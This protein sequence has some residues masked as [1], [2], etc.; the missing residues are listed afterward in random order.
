MI[1]AGGPPLLYAVAQS[2]GEGARLHRLRALPLLVLLGTGLSLGNAL[3]VLRALAGSSRGFQRTPKYALRTNQDTWV[4]S[5][6]AGEAG[7]SVWGELVLALY[8]LAL[9]SVP[10]VHWGL[11]PWLLVYAG[12]FAYVAGVS[13]YQDLKRRFWQSRARSAAGD[14]AGRTPRSGPKGIPSGSPGQDR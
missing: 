13:I 9:L 7:V 1:A 12:G 10:N 6:Y 4:G 5:T 11:V 14:T 3:A 8:S 2:E